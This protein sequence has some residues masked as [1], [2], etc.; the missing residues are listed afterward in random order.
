MTKIS[1]ILQIHN[2]YQYV[3]KDIG[4]ITDLTSKTIS[5]RYL[6]VGGGI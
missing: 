5:D 6:K 2:L 3:K 1:V 4:S